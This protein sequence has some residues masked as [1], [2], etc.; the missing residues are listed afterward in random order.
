VQGDNV[1]VKLHIALFGTGERFPV[2][3]DKKSGQPVRLATRYVVRI[4]R[5]RQQVGTIC[6]D[7]RSIGALYNW[8]ADQGIDLEDRLRRKELLTAS[9]IGGFAT[10]LRCGRQEKVI[11]RIGKVRGVLS[12]NV[13]NTN[14]ASVRRFLEWVYD[15]KLGISLSGGDL[16]KAKQ[17]L[18]YAFRAQAL[19]TT[20]T[21]RKP[22]DRSPGVEQSIS[23]A[24]AGAELFDDSLIFG[25][26]DASRRAFQTEGGGCCHTRTGASCER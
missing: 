5:A 23:Q 17:K 15:E 1:H 25:D 4:R 26:R 13:L 9:E 3:L 11:G 18:E 22:A 14:L 8:F 19:K 21:P 2:L 16:E 12:A 10:F 20:P 7:L 24:R 6:N